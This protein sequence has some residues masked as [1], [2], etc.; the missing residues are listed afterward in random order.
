MDE[1]SRPS[2]QAR[3]AERF[4]RLV[5]DVKEREADDADVDVTV[6]KEGPRAK[7]GESGSN[8]ST[9]RNE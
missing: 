2:K 7:V 1:P 6:R 8:D 3:A 9:M 5:S 4:T